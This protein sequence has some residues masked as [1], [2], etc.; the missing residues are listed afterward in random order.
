MRWN[1]VYYG[2][3]ST[4]QDQQTSSINNQQFRAEE[5]GIEKIYSD[6]ESATS[7]DR[8]GFK[9]MLTDAGLDFTIVK[10]KKEEKLV[11]MRSDRDPLFKYIYCR[12]ISRFSRN[13]LDAITIVREL[14]EKGV[15][16]V[17]EAE[18]ISTEDMASEFLLSIHSSLAQQESETISQRV[19]SG[20]LITAKKGHLRSFNNYGYKR[21]DDYLEII[22]EEAEIVR[23]I[24]KL[25]T[26]EKLGNRRIAKRLNELNYKTRNN[27]NWSESSVHNIVRNPIYTGVV[28]RNKYDCTGLFGNNSVKLK[29]EK[30]W[31]INESDKVPQIISKETYEL[32]QKQIKSFSNS[33]AKRG[34]NLGYTEFSGKIKCHKCGANYSRNI[35]SCTRRVY[36][37]CTT[38]KK[39]GVKYCDAKNIYLDTI[40]NSIKEY[41]GDG[42][43]KA[44]EGTLNKVLFRSIDKRIK[45]L[46]LSKDN[47]STKEIEVNNKKIDSLN[48]QLGK[49][50]KL[51]ITS[52]ISEE[53]L[54]SEKCSLELE[55][56]NLKMENKRLS[57]TNEEIDLE[58]KRVEKLKDTMLEFKDNITKNMTK[59]EFINKHLKWITVNDEGQIR[60]LITDLH[61]LSFQVGKLI[62]KESLDNIEEEFKKFM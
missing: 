37:N 22:E 18:N 24:Y 40:D 35:N 51:Y 60:C 58:I 32:A 53:I 34:V 44:V 55:L 10:N 2:R 59:D 14:K 36:Y 5:L 62:R 17:F 3:V 26:E 27:R 33:S 57:Q 8:D 30:E 21:V 13:I 23:F 29:D 56:N 43:R 48:E 46:N 19:R 15:Y 31:I 28:V 38:K 45:E 9:K 47:D 61:Y 49:L 50:V 16:C 4:E 42:Y 41:L 6:R 11:V 7:V 54:N 1:K 52:T 25:K 12:S 39:K 20:N